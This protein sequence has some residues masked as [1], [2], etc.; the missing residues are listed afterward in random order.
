VA[1]FTTIVFVTYP[2]L[3]YLGL[4]YFDARFVGMALVVAAGLRLVA[5]KQVQRS[6]LTRSLAGGVAVAFVIGAIV[7]FSN[8]D[9][10]LRFYPVCMNVMMLMLFAL[11]LV[12]PPTIVER[13]ARVRN[14]DL[15]ASAVRYT[16]KVTWVWCGFFVLNGSVALYTSLATSIETWTLYNGMVAYMFMATLFAGEY[17]VRRVVQRRNRTPSGSGATGA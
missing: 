15:P 9:V 13:I 12:N 4:A 11:T 14:P 3:V 8:S 10:I 5:S 17:C 6:G 2:I 7:A 16:R 1:F